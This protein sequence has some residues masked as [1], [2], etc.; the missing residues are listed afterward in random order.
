[1]K[2][3]FM[4]RGVLDCKVSDVD[5]PTEDERFGRIGKQTI[6]DTGPL[7]RERMTTIEADLVERSCDFIDR[8][9]GAGKPFLLWHNSTRMHVWTRLSERWKDKRTRRTRHDRGAVELA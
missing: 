5:D 3:F 4:P 6:T 1:M 7:T 2:R 8:A 9:H